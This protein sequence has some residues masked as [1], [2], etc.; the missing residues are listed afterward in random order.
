MICIVVLKKKTRKIEYNME[1]EKFDYLNA[2]QILFQLMKE[3]QK[4]NQFT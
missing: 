3:R 1:S 2:K 4:K